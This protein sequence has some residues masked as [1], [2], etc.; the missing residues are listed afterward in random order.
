MRIAIV[1]ADFEENIGVGMIAAAAAQAGHEVQIVAFNAPG[2]A[3][4][5]VTKTMAGSPDVIGLSIQFQHRA[6][7][8]LLLSRRLRAAGFAGHVTCGGQFPTLAWGEVLSGGHGV[9]SIVLHEGERSIRDLLDALES[10]GRIGEVP[11]LALLSDDGVPMRT[12]PRRLI[13]D[14][15]ELPFAARYRDHDRHFGIPFIPVM[16]G[17][18]CWGKCVYCSI[19]SF[20]RDAREYGGG[21]TLRQR[22]P[23]DV[24]TEMALLWHRAGG[25]SLYCFHDDNFLLPRP[26]DTVA[27]VRAI[28]EELDALDVGKIGI[29]GKARPDTVTPELMHELKALGVIRLYVGVE[30]A[31]EAGGAHLGRGRQTACIHEA[32]KACDEAGIFACYNLLIFSP[33]STLSEIRENFAFI[34]EH[35]SHPVN[36]CRAEPYHG[37]PLFES[38]RGTSAIGGSYLGWNYRMEDDRAEVLFRICASAFR[39]RN[40][41]Q[42]GVANR[43]MGLGYGMNVVEHFHEERD[44]AVARLRGRVDRATRG[45]TTESAGFLERAADLA[46]TADLSDSDLILRETARL[47]LEI[48]EADQRWHLT[49]DQLYADLNE[50]GLGALPARRPLAERRAAFGKVAKAIALS[51]TIGVGLAPLEA[52]GTTSDPLPSDSGFDSMVADPP[53]ADSGMDSMVADPPPPDSGVDSMVAD[54]PP[55]DSGMDVPIADPPPAD[56][57]M[58]VPIA[59]PPPPDASMSALSPD[60]EHRLSVI[61]QWRDSSPRRAARSDDLPLF[62]PPDVRLTCEP[63]AD[64]LKVSIV[65]GP[66]AIGTRWET[67]GEVLGDGAVVTWVPAHEDDQLR[68]AVRTNSGV[69]VVSVRPPAD[70]RRG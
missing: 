55:A 15:D 10:G 60:G 59:D 34:R 65:G 12:A 40:F 21:K 49:L 68:V 20:Y 17:R 2:D 16:G 58:D 64:G 69:S 47:G 52:C 50:Y 38:I 25:P 32:L 6:H 30:N 54:P 7:E 27:R 18:G 3:D 66:E 11:G 56:S 45:I 29:I 9:D 44:G 33:K 1:G 28:R 5:V 67:E 43:Y 4:D 42:H 35:A 61:D 53:P 22:S 8:F 62:D 14:L 36:F 26:A 57:G 41:A 63:V 31:S 24:A 39:E 70:K 48:S 46:E 13:E 37:T 51:A 19:T 23:K